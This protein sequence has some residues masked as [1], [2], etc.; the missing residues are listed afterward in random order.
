MLPVL[1]CPG[2]LFRITNPNLPNAL[3]IKR[4]SCSILWSLLIDSVSSSYTQLSS[5]QNRQ[6]QQWSISS[7]IAIPIGHYLVVHHSTFH[8][9]LTCKETEI[10]RKQINKENIFLGRES[11]SLRKQLQC[12]SFIRPPTVGPN[13]E[14]L[15]SLGLYRETHKRT[16]LTNV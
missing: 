16:T 5:Q 3:N 15:H 14:Y 9:V 6:T 4:F 2:N 8:A 13:S 1:C 11:F 7:F 10:E 12:H